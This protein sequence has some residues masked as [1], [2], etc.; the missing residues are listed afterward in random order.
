MR[1]GRGSRE[2]AEGGSPAVGWW[3][4]GMQELRGGVKWGSDDGA[5]WGFGALWLP[6]SVSWEDP[7]PAATHMDLGAAAAPWD[8][9]SR[10]RVGLRGSS[11]ARW[12]GG[13]AAPG[14]ASG[15]G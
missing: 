4:A 1:E 7:R 10:R 11:G 15:R 9:G 5:K 8:V 3:R 6:S 2:E 14:G 12:C 13:P